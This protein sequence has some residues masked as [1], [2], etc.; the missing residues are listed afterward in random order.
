MSLIPTDVGRPLGDMAQ[1]LK[2]GVDIVGAVSD[3]LNTLNSVD[4]RVEAPDGSIYQMRI[5]P[6]RT[7][8]NVI[9]GAVLTFVDITDQQRIQAERDDLARSAEAAGEFAQGVLDSMREPQLVLD[10]DLAV[11]TANQAFL[12]VFELSSDAVVGHQLSEI[13][14]GA[15][16]DDELSTLLKHVL[17]EKRT[18]GDHQLRLA[19][20]T[21]KARTITV[22]ALE[23]VR[24]SPAKRRLILL[25]VTNVGGA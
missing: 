23:L 14:H 4:S 22:N 6:Y 15:W 19:Q 7:L 8:D 9:E 20:G 16:R 13:D 11:V 1:R 10:G 17:P 2:G 21:P 25:T 18:L 12:A 3:V 24:L 5:Q